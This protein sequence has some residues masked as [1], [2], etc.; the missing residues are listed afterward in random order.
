MNFNKETINAI[1][2]QKDFN[3]NKQYKDN[4]R[5]LRSYKLAP[6]I[7][8]R[9]KLTS[10]QKGFISKR[11]NNYENIINNKY[12]FK[13]I[14]NKTKKLIGNNE[15][16]IK[17]HIYYPKKSHLSYRKKGKKVIVER[18]YSE[19]RTSK[20]IYGV[21][22]NFGVFINKINNVKLKG[23]QAVGVYINGVLMKSFFRPDGDNDFL[24][25]LEQLMNT[26]KGEDITL[27]YDIQSF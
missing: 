1:K 12:D 6:K 10:A 15:I 17:N 21:K 16:I 5:Q 22:S 9:K 7:D 27:T 19:K 14:S 2:K 20:K 11:I 25:S 3:A 24:E 18:K 26:K 13:Y 23:N 8:L 4:L